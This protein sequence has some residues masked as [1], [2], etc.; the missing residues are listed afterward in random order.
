MKN[1]FNRIAEIKNPNIK[2]EYGEDPDN[3]RIEQ[4]KSAEHTTKMMVHY[5][6]RISIVIFFLFVLA[7]FFFLLPMSQLELSET[8]RWIRVQKWVR[9][10]ISSSSTAGIAILTVIAT[11]LAKRTFDFF[12]KFVYPPS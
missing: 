7:L 5:I 10:F 3:K 9:A 6:F 4:L 11:D 8:S 1:K 2:K 12:K